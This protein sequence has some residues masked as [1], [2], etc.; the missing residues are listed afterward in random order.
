MKNKINYGVTKDDL[1]RGYSDGEKK[2][3]NKERLDR[4]AP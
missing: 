4:A 1:R 3:K 2:P